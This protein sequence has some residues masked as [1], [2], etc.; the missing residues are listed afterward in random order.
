MQTQ[1]EISIMLPFGDIKAAKRAFYWRI[2]ES[3]IFLYSFIAF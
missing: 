1:F 2:E 3:G